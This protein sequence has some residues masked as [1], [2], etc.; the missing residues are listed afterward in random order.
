MYV[1]VQLNW[2]ICCIYIQ[3]GT[4]P[5]MLAM[6]TGQ[7]DVVDLLK[8]KYGQQEPSPKAVSSLNFPYYVVSYVPM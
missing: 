7:S 8:N 2:L 1:H 5:I 3:D 4:I 6:V